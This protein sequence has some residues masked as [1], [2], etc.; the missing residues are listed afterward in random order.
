V[1]VEAEYLK[2]N[3]LTSATPS[4]G[5]YGLASYLFPQVVG[6]GKVQILG[7]YSHKSIDSTY[8]DTLGYTPSDQVKTSE[9]DLNYIIKGFNARVGLYFLDQKD[10]ISDLSKQEYGLKLQLQI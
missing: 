9:V 10:D 5:W 6:I 8:S 2:D 1:S 3:G 7:K 4:D